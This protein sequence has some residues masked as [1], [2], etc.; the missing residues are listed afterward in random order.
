MHG[1]QLWATVLGGILLG[2]VLLLLFRDSAALQRQMAQWGNAKAQ[3][4]LGMKY[5]QGRGVPK[6]DQQAAAWYQKAA[7]QGMAYA[8]TALGT[9]YEQGIG[10]TQDDQQ[11]A[12]WY[13]KAA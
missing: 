7:E 3:Y 2:A 1:K 5:A 9:M 12:A 6:D 10:V 4:N 11:A 13:K 8:Q